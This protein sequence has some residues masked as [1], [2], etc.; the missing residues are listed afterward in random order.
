MPQNWFLVTSEV[1]LLQHVFHENAS[2]FGPML[3][4]GHFKELKY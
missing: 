1:L 3:S 2:Y 4:Y